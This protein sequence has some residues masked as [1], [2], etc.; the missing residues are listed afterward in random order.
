MTVTLSAD[1]SVQQLYVFGEQPLPDV[2]PT[3]SSTDFQLTIPVGIR[4]G[5][6][7]LT[8]AGLANGVV[9]KSPPLSI[10][11][12]RNDFPVRVQ[13]DPSEIK[14]TEAQQLIPLTV[15]GTFSDGSQV[16]IS[17]SKFTQYTSSN[18]AVATVSSIGV[19]AAV[20]AGKARISVS[21]P[22]WP[23]IQCADH[24]ALIAA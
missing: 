9:V 6:Y 3:Q 21:T 10:D 24:I 23:S 22:G 13:V 14:F 17:R 4:A 2:Q 19:A 16:D 8:A 1:P 15:T 12:E 11:V 18:P 7:R 20:T 5:S